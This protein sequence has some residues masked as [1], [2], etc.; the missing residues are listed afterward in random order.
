MPKIEEWGINKM[1]Q[2]ERKK[3]ITFT[4]RQ[5][6]KINYI[7]E[8]QDMSISEAIRNALDLYFED[9][10]GKDY[11]DFEEYIKREEEAWGNFER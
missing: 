10:Y 3:S 1:S 2:I 4:D 8:D 5:I 7:C 11:P 9:I 6:Y